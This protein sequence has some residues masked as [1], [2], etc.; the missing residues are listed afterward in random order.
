MAKNITL[1]KI[2]FTALFAALTCVATMV[3][4]IPSPTN[5]YVN[6]GDCIVLVS[7][8]LLGPVYGTL[9]AAIGSGLADLF[10]GYFIYIPGTFVIKGLTA[11]T[12]CLIYKVLSGKTSKYNLVPLTV[13]AVLGEIVMVSGYVVYEAALPGI[14]IA[15][16]LASVPGNIAQGIAGVVLSVI[17]LQI[18]KKAKL[19][20][21]V[22]L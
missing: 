6:L 13:G 2:I 22:S 21:R 17:L 7:G 16:A 19:I 10:G 14:N 5:G 12:A 8:F 11:L 20:S 18:F 15:A 1:K 3:I 9:A 4:R